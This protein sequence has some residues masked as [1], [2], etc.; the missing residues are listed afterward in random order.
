MVS[1]HT[2]HY[3][4]W[5]TYINL[6]RSLYLYMYCGNVLRFN[7][8]RLRFTV[9]LHSPLSQQKCTIRPDRIFLIILS[10]IY[11]RFY[12]TKQTL[13]L[14]NCCCTSWCYLRKHFCN[15]S[16]KVQSIKEECLHALIL[17]V[18]QF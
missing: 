12:V 14:I 17:Y 6:V 18:Q 1:S 15:K 9:L 7:M 3:E 11:K 16:V 5:P 2:S 13:K 4:T 8:L 10:I